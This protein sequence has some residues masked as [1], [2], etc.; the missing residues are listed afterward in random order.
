MAAHRAELAQIAAQPEPPSFANT[1]A[2]FDRA[3][4]LLSC[5]RA[6]FRNLTASATSAKLQAVA[7]VRR[8]LVAAVRAAGVD[9]TL[10]EPW[11]WRYGAEASGA[12]S[13]PST[14]SR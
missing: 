10:I 9:S 1:V 8:A 13:A 14:T 7:R 6:V 4:R 5:V 2:A 3:G 12:G 11:D